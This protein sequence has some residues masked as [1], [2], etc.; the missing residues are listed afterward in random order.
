MCWLQA[1][2]VFQRLLGKHIELA[3]RESIMASIGLA[4]NLTALALD[5]DAVLRDNEQNGA[6]PVAAMEHN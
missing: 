1:G 4:I 3:A 5:V 2:P 6:E